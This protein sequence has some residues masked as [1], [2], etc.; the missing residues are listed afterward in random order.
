[1]NGTGLFHAAGR[2]TLRAERLRSM[3]LETVP[4]ISPERVR[5]YTETYRQHEAEPMIVRRARA[6][7]RALR[8]MSL[9]ILDGELIVGNTA[10]EPR[11]V[12]LFPEYEVGWLEKELAGDP[13][14]FDRRPADRYLIDGPTRE[15][16]EE[17]LPWWHGRTHYERVDAVLPEQVRKAWRMGAVDASWLM[18]GGDGHITVG[19][20]ALLEKGVRGIL[21]D[22]DA[23]ECSLDP[24]DPETAEKMQ[25]YRA[26][27]LCLNALAGWAGRYADYAEALAA[28]AGGER[29]EELLDVAAAC[30]RVPLEPASGLQEALQSVWF[31][32]AA[33][34]IES[35][36]HAVSLGRLDQ[37]L[38]PYYRADMEHGVL[39]PGRAAELLQCF[40]LKLFTVNR[41][42]D[43]NSTQFFAGYQAYQ[44]ITVGGQLYGG[45]DASN[46]L[47]FLM[48]GVQ[49]AVSLWVPSLSF[50]YF[51]G[52]GEELLQAAIEV[53]AGGGGQPAFYSD[54]V[55]I[56]SLLLRGV[57]Y[58]DAVN[59]SVVGCVEPIVE[60]RQTNRPNG[61]AFISMLKILEVAL[62]GGRDPR[63]GETLLPVTGLDQAGSFEQVKRSWE[64]LARHCVELQL[65]W[66]NLIDAARE[67]LNPD[68]LASCFVEDCIARGKT[69]KQGGAV[70]DFCGP[71]LCGL[72]NVGDSLAALRRLVFQER[73]LTADRLIHALVTD[74][75]DQ[76]TDPPGSRIR[77]MLLAAPKYGNDREE[78]DALAAEALELFCRLLPR[79]R[80]TRHGRGPR[81]GV[82]LASCSTVS[83]NVPFGKL[84]GATPDGR[85]AGTPTADTTSP[86]QGADRRG[87]LST[88]KSAAR[89]PN[90][91]CTGGN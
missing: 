49:K 36:G 45:R 44:N 40:W 8:D 72:A 38:Y 78:A 87:P 86:T 35:S 60:G 52:T 63:T 26:A 22:I 81:G 34:Q 82:W 91:L 3:L 70:Y 7:D 74:F 61:A 32:Q 77:E 68:P 76:E 84:V 1:M 56:P 67:E 48:L 14:P 51:D 58:E 5:F 64:E 4:R 13:Y 62:H 23:A 24:A 83:G 18:Q 19:Y 6:L 41:I 28:E 25:F 11:G 15:E 43:W 88:M 27:R 39:T 17:L 50:R 57:S 30:R 55:M 71:L 29:R 21:R 75:Q 42:K 31:L 46:E 69:L 79:Y 59:W 85:R 20:R 47:S 33:Q 54:E 65:A 53:S 9:Y 16:L 10:R 73:S 12:E 90:L 80:T 66:D 89:I 37:T 2:R